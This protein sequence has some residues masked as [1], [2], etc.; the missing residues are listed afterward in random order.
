MN[1]YE[2]VE[3]YLEGDNNKK[4]KEEKKNSIFC[5]NASIGLKLN[6]ELNTVV[7]Q[8]KQEE[9]EFI[10]KRNIPINL[11]AEIKN[12][13]IN[14]KGSKNSI[15]SSI[16]QTFNC[17]KDDIDAVNDYISKLKSNK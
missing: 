5:E 15:K 7:E 16:L 9:K 4:N 17:S 8:L 3:R 13:L 11:Y 14:T 2:D 6:K 12:K 10:K 1:T